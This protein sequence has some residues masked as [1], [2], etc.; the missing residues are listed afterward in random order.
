MFDS[1]RIFFPF[2]LT[3][4]SKIHEYSI[5]P[6]L[7]EFNAVRGRFLH[8]VGSEMWPLLLVCY[9]GGQ[10]SRLGGSDVCDRWSRYSP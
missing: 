3:F 9:C 2:F 7:P 5:E 4:S 10:L 1:E 6:I 8:V